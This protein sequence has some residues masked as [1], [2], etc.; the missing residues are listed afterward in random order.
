MTTTQTPPRTGLVLTPDEA[1]RAAEPALEVAGR[2]P[3]SDGPE[4]LQEAPLF[5]AR[6]PERVQRLLRAEALDRLEGHCV[7]SSHLIDD[8]HIGLTPSH[9]NDETR[10]HH[11][12]PEEILLVL[13]AALVGEPFGW[14]TDAVPVGVAGVDFT[15]L[16]EDELDVLFADRFHLLPDSSH[17][18]TNNTVTSDRDQ[19]LFAGI[20]K[21]IND[22]EPF[23]VLFGSRRDPCCVSTPRT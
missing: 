4:L 1:R 3:T 8:L 21:I 23:S 2:Y 10:P 20:E 5:S 11:E 7:L 9:W 13:Y 22:R 18:P 16:P 6:R 15:R 19:Q 14:A 12:L 17:L